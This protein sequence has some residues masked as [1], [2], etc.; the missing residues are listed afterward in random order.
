MQKIQSD[1]KNDPVSDNES[2]KDDWQMCMRV[3]QSVTNNSVS[4]RWQIQVYSRSIKSVKENP[5]SKARSQSLV[6]VWQK[7]SVI[8]WSKEIHSKHVDLNGHS[9]YSPSSVKQIGFILQ[10]IG[11]I[12]VY[13][14]GL[15]GFRL[16]P[17]ESV[18][19]SNGVSLKSIPADLVNSRS[20]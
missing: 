3:H 16:Y 7:M 6:N 14:I 20:H 15:S 2:P 13:S 12:L 17:V 5:F 9:I 1:V 8:C 4:C 18:V 19:D 11:L 10:S